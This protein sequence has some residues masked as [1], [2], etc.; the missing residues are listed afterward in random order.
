MA[1]RRLLDLGNCSPDHGTLTRFVSQHFSAD[2]A[3]AHDEDEALAQ[4]REG[5]FD[6]VIVNRK[7]DRDGSDGLE[8]IERL[9]ADAKLASVPVML[10]TNYAD[11][12]DAAVKLGAE[13]GFG[14]SDYAKPETVEKLRPF[15]SGK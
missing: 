5:Q 15:L 8:I 4:L 11:Y 2:V 7:L 9:K 6:L 13:R 3:W 12:Q 14:K 10:L 1:I